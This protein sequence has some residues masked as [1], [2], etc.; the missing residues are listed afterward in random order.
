MSGRQP[1]ESPPPVTR[2]QLEGGLRDLGVSA[3][4][5]VMVHTSMRALGWIAGGPETV[6]R[7]LLSV[8]GPEGTLMAYAG[9][10]QD[11]YHLEQWPAS[12][13]DAARRE[14]P[15]F[16]PTLSEAN[17]DHGRVPERMRTWPGAVR[18]P[19]PEA[20][21]VAIGRDAAALVAPHPDD[22]PYGAGTPLERLV[23]ID[24]SV[25]LLGA[26]LDA[27]TLLHHAEAIAPIEDKRRT[28]Y[29][30]PMLV[31]G[32]TVWRTFHDI[33][34]SDGAFDYARLGLAV[35]PFE[36]IVQDA[37]EAG[38][39]RSGVVGAATS[40]LLPARALTDFAVAWLVE[41]FGPLSDDV[42]PHE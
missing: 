42:D 7:A 13:R 11:P 36:Q 5:V 20:S 26:P 29:D 8:L 10:D 2:S 23:A 40:V 18:G 4:S 16:D 19:H 31:D 12:V 3:A 39:G 30:M 9:W 6:V 37:L 27:V 1:S 41:R 33:D 17:R 35:D 28:V 34:T 15:P 22:D 32:A 14:L 24:G 25:L 38:I 21:M